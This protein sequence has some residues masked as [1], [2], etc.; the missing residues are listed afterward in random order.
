MSDAE[1]K[2]P[3]HEPPETGSVGRA[4]ET[5]LPAAIT[6]KLGEFREQ[7]WRVKFT[8]IALAAIFGLILSFIFVFILDRFFETPGL[9]RGLI[10][11]AGVAVAAI[12]LPLV[13]HRWVVRQRRFEDVA[14]LVRRRF[15]K[16]GDQLLGTIELAHETAEEGAAAGRSPRLVQ[17]AIAQAAGAV[18][19]RDL[20]DAVPA[21][22]Q[23]QWAWAAGAIAVI[24]LL[25]ALF[26]PK[27]ARNALSRWFLPGSD[28]ERYTFAQVDGAPKELV[29]PFAENFDLETHLK[30]ESEWQPAT[31]TAA[32]PGQPKL[33]RE[34]DG[35][36]GAYGFD[37]PPQKEDA[38]IALRV[39]DDR[40]RIELKPR[41]R[42]EL[43]ALTGSVRLPK[44]LEYESEPPVEVRG[45]AVRILKGASVSWIAEARR[46]LKSATLDGLEQPVSGSK[47]QTHYISL[48][49]SKEHQFNWVDELNLTPRE[50]V[51][52]RVQAIEDAAPGISA[53]R[54]SL[55]KVVLETEVIPFDISVEDD[56]GVKRVGLEWFSPYKK[57]GQKDAAR[58]EKV[59]AAGAPET[60]NI[61]PRATFCAKRDGVKPQTLLVRAWAEDYLPGRERSYSSAFEL[62]ILDPTD[63]A[64]WLN[65]EFGK[66]LGAAKETYEREQQLHEGN[67]EI[68]EMSASDLDRPEVRRQIAEQAA[69][70]Q[71]NA[72]RLDQL[73][74]IGRKLVEQGTKNEEFDGQR[75]NT[76]AEMIDQLDDIAEKRMP[77]VADLLSQSSRA[78]ASKPQEA[79]SESKPGEP[80][81][82]G[83]SKPQEAK[84][85]EGEP[86]GG[87]SQKGEDK[88][89]AGEPSGGPS[90]KIP[91]APKVENGEQNSSKGGKTP[92]QEDDGQEQPAVPQ[93]ADNEKSYLEEDEKPP[94][95]GGGGKSAPKLSL[96]QTTLGAA[97]G[98]E[99]ECPTD[100]GGDTPAKEKLDQAVD[101]QADLLNDFAKIADQLS[102]LL[103]SLEAAT[104]VKR[105]KAASQKQME[106]AEGL[107]S[108]TLDAF[109]LT[110]HD[111]AATATEAATEIAT[112]AKD[113][114]QSV[115]LIQSDLGAYLTRKPDPRFD[116]LLQSMKDERVVRELE[117]MAPT[118]GE[119][120][121]GRSIAASEFW[122]DTLDRW[123]EELVAAAAPP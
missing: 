54:D 13:Y 67:K 24:A 86:S 75:L 50:P 95:E 53:T 44:Y 18:E 82:S 61:A 107:N 106:I 70:E 108:R 113:E 1:S 30:A 120:L 116:K 4:P 66:W 23:R 98:Q 25:A 34:Q 36:T 118:M 19:D 46:A 71:A 64:M 29:V 6:N 45:G 12:G 100:E 21:P 74:D 55:E 41:T 37:F 14:R 101:E 117:E 31:A 76:W 69:N 52:L 105:L 94:S 10:L 42:P 51:T 48:D 65:E 38:S 58:G 103:G 35:E 112:V 11:I 121:T 56:F 109:G 115:Y 62:K 110:V 60:K 85:G 16:L 123:A 17:A 15:P 73:N 99:A 26:V 97:P 39:G 77:T 96:P 43:V 81:E 63:H 93:I 40:E 2:S 89:E 32:I 28:T 79:G 27:A 80:G 87:E 92:E 20:S 119:N 7:V 59:A 104:F 47:V 83:E 102:E 84:P 91:E 72:D 33:R 3:D 114:T 22:K 57:P 5:P 49:T 90:S 78:E 88:P 8:E 111:A 68:R 9:V 122:A